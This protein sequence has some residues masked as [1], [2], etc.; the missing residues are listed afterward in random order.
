MPEDGPLPRGVLLPAAFFA[1]AGL[2]ELAL[3]IAMA[4]APTSFWRLWEALGRGTLHVLVAAGLLKRIA[5]CRSIAMIY[6]LASLTTYGIVLAL[7]LGHAPFHYPP[8]MVVQSLYE[9]PLSAVLFPFLR[10]RQASV[11]FT[12]PLF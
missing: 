8:G 4:P 11:L 2:L 9:V 10:S 7:A 12:R 1:V 5:V 3:G 6:C